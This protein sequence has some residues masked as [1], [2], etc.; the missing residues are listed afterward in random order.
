MKN[1][2]MPVRYLAR[3]GFLLL[4]GLAASG[5]AVAQTSDDPFAGKK[6]VHLLDEPRHRT[7]FNDDNVYLLDVQVNPGDV[8]FPHVHDSA[9]L[10]TY[11]S[12]GDGPANGR[13]GMNTD[14]ASEPYTHEVS[15]SGPGLLEFHRRA[16][17][18]YWQRVLLSTTSFQ[19]G[20]RLHPEPLL[21]GTMMDLYGQH[22]E[23]WRGS[24]LTNL[25]GFVALRLL[26]HGDQDSRISQRRY[27]RTRIQRV[28][29]VSVLLT[30]HLSEEETGLAFCHYHHQ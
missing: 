4:L 19:L 23:Y 13:L 24:C 6:I 9:I 28:G 26:W 16:Q 20:Q 30:L 12:R 3:H 8:S 15:N 10:L 21:V 1:H 25:T 29:Q 7:V 14:Y 18:L 17:S 27:E 22:Q 11:I 2:C 5:L